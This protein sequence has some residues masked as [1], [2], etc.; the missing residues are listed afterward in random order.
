[1]IGAW[2]TGC[3]AAIR[4]YGP[5]WKEQAGAGQMRVTTAYRLVAFAGPTARQFGLTSGSLAGCRLVPTLRL[6]AERYSLI[7]FC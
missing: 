6:G 7:A 5:K 4:P 3:S 1:M 2:I